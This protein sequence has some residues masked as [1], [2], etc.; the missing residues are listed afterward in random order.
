MRSARD[1]LTVA[2]HRDVSALIEGRP[3]FLAGHDAVA[4]DCAVAARM[5]P[6]LGV[7]SA[8]LRLA[9]ECD[10]EEFE[11]RLPPG[12]S[13]QEVLLLADGRKRYVALERCGHLATADPVAIDAWLGDRPYERWYALRDGGHVAS[14]DRQGLWS[15]PREFVSEVALLPGADRRLLMYAQRCEDD[16]AALMAPADVVRLVSVYP[17]ALVS[18]DWLAANLPLRELHS[19]LIGRAQ[20][21][22]EEPGVELPD[23][24]WLAASPI[25]AEPSMLEDALR[26]HGHLPSSDPEWLFSVFCG[27]DRP[28]WDDGREDNFFCA[29]VA[30]GHVSRLP[31]DWLARRLPMRLLRAAVSIGQH[32][33]SAEDIVRYFSGHPGCHWIVRHPGVQ[34][35]D[36]TREFIEQNFPEESRPRILLDAG[37]LADLADLTWIEEKVDLGLR[38]TVLL[39]TRARDH[40]TPEWVA[41]WIAD[42][43]VVGTLQ[44]LGFLESRSREWMMQNLRGYALLDC[45]TARGHGVLGGEPIRVLVDLYG[46]ARVSALQG[47]VA[48]EDL[49]RHFEPADMARLLS[50]PDVSPDL[51][52]DEIARLLDYVEVLVFGVLRARNLLETAPKEWLQRHLNG[53]ILTI[54][55]ETGGHM[56][57]LS[58]A[59]IKTLAADSRSS[60]QTL[61]RTARVAQMSAD[62]VLEVFGSSGDVLVKAL[63]FTGLIEDCD[64]E[65]LAQH[66]RG[67]ALAD[68]VRDTRAYRTMAPERYPRYDIA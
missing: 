25:A 9:M 59:E 57:D 27:R 32:V 67:D 7:K 34:V 46:N 62:E 16:I 23:A 28:P 38:S 10:A 65:V 30:G 60:A 53:V 50:M 3:T 36:L 15:L 39:E 22:L 29:L 1:A 68:A 43:A 17:R 14:I 21:A 4:L 49:H 8:I 63:L 56:L 42:A 64:P 2:L 44:A 51:S 52:I 54:A 24:E 37:H 66:L 5:G 55:L 33:V 58:V 48:P 45:M 20:K 47:I 12:A 13:L 26:T 35:R 18:C 61:M 41:R 19:A 40:A 6:Y 31:L 11:A